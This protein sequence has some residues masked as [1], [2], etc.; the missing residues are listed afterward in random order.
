MAAEPT[1]QVSLEETATPAVLRTED[2]IPDFSEKT[3]A[4]APAGPEANVEPST[5]IVDKLVNDIVD[6]CVNSAEV[7]NSGSDTEASRQDSAKRDEKGHVRTSSAKRPATFKSVS[8]NKTFLASKATSST[9]APKVGDKPT[10]PVSSAATPTTSSSV[11]KPR[12]VAKTTSGLRDASKSS[13]SQN[14]RP[15]PDASAVWNKNRPIPV[16]DPRKITD[17]ELAKIGIHMASRLH[18]DDTKGQS[19]WADIDDDD[20]DWDA[21][22]ALTWADGTK[23]TIPHVD[24]TPVVPEPQPAIKETKAIE[25]PRSPAPPSAAASSSPSVKPGLPS[26]KGLILKGGASAEKPTLVAKPPAPPTPVKSPWASLPP[27]SKVS[28][29]EVA[30]EQPQRSFASP[31]QTYV[32]GGPPPA[33][34]E[35]AAD[36]FSRSPRRDNQQLFNSQSGRYE[37]VPDRRGIARTD[38]PQRQPAVL[39]RPM[40]TETQGPAEPSAAFQ[41]THTSGGYGRR[42]GSSNVSGGSGSFQRLRSIDQTIPPPDLHDPRR[43]S[44]ISVGDHPLSPHNH[45][46]SVGQAP[47]RQSPYLPRAS[48]AMSSVAPQPVPD[49]AI[50]A[51]P[52]QNIENTVEFQKKLM[53]ERRAEAIKRRQEQEA[54]EEAA[55]KERLAKKLAA[56]GP[57]PDRRGVKKEETQE[58][59]Q[60]TTEQPSSAPEVPEQTSNDAQLAQSTGGSK[61]SPLANG[62]AVTSQA[63]PKPIG[64]PE[65]PPATENKHGHPWQQPRIPPQPEPTIW[66]SGIQ[67]SRNV[68]GAPNNDRTLGNGSFNAGF[69]AQLSQTA[70]ARGGRPGP[71]PIAPPRAA[72]PGGSSSSRPL[73]PIGPP[74]D[75]KTLNRNRF[76]EQVLAGDQAFFAS[77]TQRGAELDRDLKAR[78]LTHA[79]VQPQIKEQYTALDENGNPIKRQTTTYGAPVWPASSSGRQDD[80]ASPAT[81]RSAGRNGVV[82]ASQQSR[83]FPASQNAQLEPLAPDT[84][85][86]PEEGGSHPAFDGDARHPH[87][88]LPSTKPVPV[89][90]LPPVPGSTSAASQR[91]SQSASTW[92]QQPRFRDDGLGA[93]HASRIAASTAATASQGASIMDRIKGLFADTKQPT[94]V[95]VSSR[96]AFA[97]PPPGSPAT[98][99]LP[100]LYAPEGIVDSS[101][102]VTKTMDEDCF[103]EQEMGSLPPVNIPT[104]IPEA[105]YNPAKAPP[106]QDRRLAQV[107]A[108]T[109]EAVPFHPEP[110]NTIVICL[111][112]SERKS[113]AMALRS[114]N[115]RRGGRPGS[116]YGSS[117]YRGG[118]RNQDASTPYSPEQASASGA[119]TGT[120]NTRGRGR[121]YRGRSSE[122]GRPA[123]PA[124]QTQ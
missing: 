40:H 109:A 45:A 17:E 22:D 84:G 38:Y 37:P 92:G 51:A 86:P 33:A 11:P 8:V 104:D 102:F 98:V 105:A 96:T 75:T 79:D 108:T 55:K 24:E 16:P 87:V 94:S 115:S 6:E 67:G 44:V 21:P 103:E 116:R 23:T 122:W 41:T 27:V 81:S 34:R 57:P 113:V 119:G 25:K 76:A 52:Q 1:P 120:G 124:I 46:S 80:G 97:H 77:A 117:S 3:S 62:V 2:G 18:A 69:D 39:Q 5:T 15:A 20:E 36:D 9:S 7:S 61:S 4:D 90:K 30:P 112:F 28:P 66:G 60:T 48:P 121:G 59:A 49:A 118:P 95:T 63:H 42:R 101:S 35:I 91:S 26:G 78:G 58:V 70:A 14:G 111:P 93:G 47:P 71:G 12:L 19:T 13:L 56:L 107:V 65:Q 110:R 88:S 89:V 43:S 100:L 53:Q 83:F 114:P 31:G 68:W 123:A 32:R 106:R 54:Q 74:Q 50:I 64:T 82:A 85:N 72:A 10:T 73:G 29:M 99:S